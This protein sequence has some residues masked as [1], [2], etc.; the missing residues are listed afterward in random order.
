MT[1]RSY[2]DLQAQR[3]KQE[4]DR[5]GWA[6]DT[7]VYAQL[8]TTGSGQ[9]TTEVSFGTAFEGAP[10]FAFGVSLQDDEILADGDAPFVSC[11]VVDW[12]K[13]ENSENR[14]PDIYL[15]ATV[16]VNVS[17]GKDYALTHRFAFEGM[18][19]KNIQFIEA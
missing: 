2:R 18:A 4:F 1:S 5:G 11:G 17:S 7:V 3:R 10:F 16:W 9:F 19:F 15:G 6:E 12:L 8:D 13:A 14:E